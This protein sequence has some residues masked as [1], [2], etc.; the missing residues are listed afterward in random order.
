MRVPLRLTRSPPVGLSGRRARP[1][2]ALAESSSA[3][4]HQAHYGDCLGKS[5]SRCR[6]C[7]GR[8]C[9]LP[10]VIARDHSP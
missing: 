7:A 6:G 9:G 10:S 2:A 1:P 4:I 5:K 8:R 3:F